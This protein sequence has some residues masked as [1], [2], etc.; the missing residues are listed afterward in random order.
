MQKIWRICCKNQTISAV[1]T[2]LPGVH[3]QQSSKHFAFKSRSR[4]LL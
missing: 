4:G 2:D 1:C 3:S